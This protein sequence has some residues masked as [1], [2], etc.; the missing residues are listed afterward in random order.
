M[1]TLLKDI[2]ELKDNLVM[3][4]H[5]KES[6]E[7]NNRRN[8][9]SLSSE[10]SSVKKALRALTDVFLKELDDVRKEMMKMNKKMK[11]KQLGS[12]K[13]TLHPAE[14]GTAPNPKNEPKQLEPQVQKGSM[15]SMASQGV[16]ESAIR[17]LIESDM[18]KL[19]LKMTKK[20]SKKTELLQNKMNLMSSSSGS[21]TEEMIRRLVPTL[22]DAQ[23]ASVIQSKQEAMA[24]EVQGLHESISA[25]R[26]DFSTQEKNTK[27]KLKSNL[28]EIEKL[29]AETMN[30]SAK[31]LEDL[32]QEK[33]E[34][35]EKV[36]ASLE[37]HESLIKGHEEQMG[38]Q[39]SI[40]QNFEV[41][42]NSINSHDALIK[43]N[44][45]ALKNQE[46]AM[47]IQE[48]T[49]K[50][51][52]GV[53][54]GFD[55]VLSTMEERNSKEMSDVRESLEEI[56]KNFE[57]II[58]ENNFVC[59][60]NLEDLAKNFEASFSEAFSSSLN[61]Q[62]RIKELETSI[63]AYFDELGSLLADHEQRSTKKFKKIEGAIKELSD[64]LQITNPLYLA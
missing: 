46:E 30:Q 2:T 5:L 7:S 4:T 28:S 41:L 6:H 20:I 26:A 19:E 43:N 31:T 57:Q 56:S 25:I 13:G 60:Q 24:R 62:E 14:T 51:L 44:E 37:N 32:R 61:M 12:S 22:F 36:W 27:R 50:N 35:L 18:M 23:K 47:G 10:V 33:Q 54:S 64:K 39:E 17:T 9:L 8:I 52:E 40:M 15:I 29:L 53:V 34:E 3:E 45:V 58:K 21:A 49:I 11:K 16:S 55:E 59:K 48:E 42:I 38:S 63:K 1:D